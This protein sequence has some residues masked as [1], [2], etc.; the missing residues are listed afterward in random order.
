VTIQAGAERL[1]YKNQDYLVNSLCH[2][3]MKLD[4]T[5]EIRIAETEQEE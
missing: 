4:A 1:G 3:V 5:V 2:A